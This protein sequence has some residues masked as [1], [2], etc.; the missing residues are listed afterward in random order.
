M[1]ADGIGSFDNDDGMEWLDG[2]GGDGASA[3]LAALETVTDLDADDFLAATEA[4]HALAAAEVVAA[5]RD[6][7]MSRIPKDAIP[8]VKE[9]VG[10][11]G[12]AKLVG[13]ARKAVARVLKQSELKETWEDSADAEDWDDNVREL[14][15]R[16]KG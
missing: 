16:L 15:E 3:V 11:I 8:R 14:L 4:A 9:N 1:S 2:F 13:T 5:A 12:A 10:K 6:G 7:D